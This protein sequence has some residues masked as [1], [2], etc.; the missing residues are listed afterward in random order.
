[1]KVDINI[2]TFCIYIFT[3][4]LLYIGVGSFNRLNN[5]KAYNKKDIQFVSRRTQVTKI[6]DSAVE[7]IEN[8]V[9]KND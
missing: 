6:L 8:V 2:V 4:I 3:L 1:M 7:T 5:E 9:G